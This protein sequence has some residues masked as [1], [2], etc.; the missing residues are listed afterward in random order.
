LKFDKLTSTRSERPEKDQKTQMVRG[1]SNAD[2]GQ[3]IAGWDHKVPARSSNRC[4]GLV[5]KSPVGHPCY[6]RTCRFGGGYTALA[7]VADSHPIHH[8]PKI[9]TNVCRVAA[10]AADETPA[11]MTA[12]TMA[13]PM[14]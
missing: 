3:W 2:G 4:A 6:G 13:Q 11:K 14:L 8:P 10:P 5:G 9:N 1:Q 12:H 7:I